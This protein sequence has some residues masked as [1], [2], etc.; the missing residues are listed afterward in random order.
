MEKFKKVIS[1]FDT[2]VS[3]FVETLSQ[4]SQEQINKVPFE[5]SWTAGQV[6]QHILKAIHGMPFLLTKGPVTK[7]ERDYDEKTEQL[8]KLFLNFD[9][10]MKSPDFIKPEETTYDKNELVHSLS[11]TKI[12]TIEAAKDK[13]LSLLCLAF[14]MPGSGHLTLYELLAFAQV[15]TIRHN[16]QLKNIYQEVSRKELINK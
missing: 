12:K 15:H 9:I 16:H 4:F 7:A 1:G 6:A 2:A 10:K 11:E 13:D 8:D 5:G 14:E 3:E